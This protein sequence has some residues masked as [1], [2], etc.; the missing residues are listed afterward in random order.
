MELNSPSQSVGEDCLYLDVYVPAVDQSISKD[1]PRKLPVLVKLLSGELSGRTSSPYYWRLADLGKIIV[2]SVKHRTGVLGY[3]ATGAAQNYGLEDQRLAMQWVWDNIF[4]FGGNPDEITLFGEADTAL[5]VGLHAI[6]LTSRGL[7]SRAITHGGSFVGPGAVITNSSAI[8][9]TVMLA[10]SLGCDTI[11]DFIPCLRNTSLNSL[12]EQAAIL[13]ELHPPWGRGL[14]RPV[15]DGII[16]SDKP[17]R[18]L[19]LGQIKIA[20]YMIGGSLTNTGLGCDEWVDSVR[21][22]NYYL[23]K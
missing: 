13:E 15:V 16:V 1:S 23:T 4:E 7:F 9:S 5:C 14:W 20:E 21:T 19:E 10:K 12:L 3:L 6:S 8:T 18:M 2:V 17:E 11:M 22:Y